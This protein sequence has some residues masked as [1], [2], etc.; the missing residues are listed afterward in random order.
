MQP[1]EG[2]GKPFFFLAALPGGNTDVTD[3]AWRP[4]SDFTYPE[5]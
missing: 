1:R 5:R 3:P 4:C 2:E